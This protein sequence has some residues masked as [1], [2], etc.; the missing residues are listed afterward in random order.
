[1]VHIHDFL[2][3]SV[4]FSYR[5]YLGRSKLVSF[6][7]VPPATSLQLLGENSLSARQYEVPNE[8]VSRHF[9]YRHFTHGR[10]PDGHIHKGH[11]PDQ[12]KDLP[13]FLQFHASHNGRFLDHLN[14]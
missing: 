8:S 11:F 4:S 7:Y 1:M 2:K 14:K 3:A 12:K 6:I 13:L 10:F 5:L 9:P